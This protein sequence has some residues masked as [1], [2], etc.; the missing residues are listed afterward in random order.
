[1]AAL[2]KLLSDIGAMD[3]LI[4]IRQYSRVADA[5][6]GWIETASYLAED[7]WAKIEYTARSDEGMRGDNQ[8]IVAYNIVKFTFRD[9]WDTLDETM[10]IV[11][12]GS[13]Y[14]IHSISKTGRSRFAIVEAE[15]RDN[16]T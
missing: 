1:M 15:K 8:Q 9:F 11:F 4:S 13:E 3:Q 14:D 6:G 10:R 2:S 5:T 12:E 7:V 16:L